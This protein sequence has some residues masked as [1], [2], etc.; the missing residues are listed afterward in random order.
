MEVA[1]A[2]IDCEGSNVTYINL[3][4]PNLDVEQ[5]V[6]NPVFCS[7]ALPSW[8]LSGEAGVPMIS[9]DMRFWLAM[10]RTGR[11]TWAETLGRLAPTLHGAM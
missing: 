8:L 7:R 2:E 11:R 6:P 3:F 10:P 4:G 5:F 1:T 9:T